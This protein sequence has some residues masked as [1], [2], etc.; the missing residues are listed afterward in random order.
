M[1]N[2]KILFLM[3]VC[4]VAAF[5][6]S[7][8]IDGIIRTSADDR[9]VSLQDEKHKFIKKTF[10]GIPLID[11]IE[12]KAQEKSFN[13]NNVEY[14]LKLQL[15]GIGETFSSARY[16][17]AMVLKSE[18]KSQLVIG[19]TLFD[20]Y[21]AIIDLLEQEAKHKLY[22]ELMDVYVDKIKVMKK[23]STVDPDFEITELIKVENDNLKALASDMECRKFADLASSKL[24]T[25]LSDQDFTEIDTTGILPVDSL[26]LLVENKLDNNAFKLD[27]DNVHFRQYKIDLDIEEERY[28]LEKAEARKYLSHIGFSYDNGEHL[29][30]IQRRN[31]EKDYNLNDAFSLEVGITL[32]ILT[33]RPHDVVKRKSDIIKAKDEYETFKEE[34]Q[35][36]FTEDINDLKY[37]IIQYLILK[38]RELEVD[39]EA[40]LKKYLE[41]KG[42]D[43]L[44]LLSIKE[45][46]IKNQLNRT[47]VIYGLYRNY[48][49]VLDMTGGIVKWPTKNFLLQQ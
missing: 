39:A 31:D 17:K 43:P 11:K 34:L 9:R 29:D 12:L 4:G 42:A 41:F 25:L 21:M 2:K 26:L 47:D 44:V 36:L 16:R 15:R 22:Q 45:N 18:Q 6:K 38:A 10:P 32:P 8:T 46:I 23:M 49:Q 14:S 24:K 7:Y 28:K 13:L 27:S 33:T 30:Q 1:N 5:G 19:R 3:L 48:I 20:R 35:Y 40:S 37:Y